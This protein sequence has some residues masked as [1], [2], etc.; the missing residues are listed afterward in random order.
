MKKQLLTLAVAGFLAMTLTPVQAEGMNLVR[1]GSF[2]QGPN[3]GGFLTFSKGSRDLLGWEIVKGSVDYIGTYFPN[4]HGKRSLDM[5][6]SAFGGIRQVVRTEPGK[7]YR[8]SFDMG[9][10]PDGPPYMKRLRVNA[11]A[12]T[13]EFTHGEGTTWHKK[14]MEF[15]ANSPMTPLEFISANT[16]AGAYGALLDNV[17]LEE[18]PSLA[19]PSRENLIVNGSF[20][21][22]IQPGEYKILKPGEKSVTGWI[23]TRDTV[24]YIGSY[25]PSSHGQRSLDLDGTPGF[26]GIRQEFRTEP[27]KK[28]RLTFDLAG[29]P[30]G[31][32]DYKRLGVKVNDHMA[33]FTHDAST[34]WTKQGLEFTAQG[35][36]TELEFFSMNREGD[37]YGPLLDNVVVEEAPEESL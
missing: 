4:A 3:P 29:N 27:G 23:I 31:A 10:N 8:L 6:G 36:T 33:I 16:E 19:G 30:E 13:R 15:T 37:Y 7:R 12:A 1:N 24:D 35:E 32:P 9:G 28:Y 17:R 26:G 34:N 5:D 25:F 11:G 20:E 21:E 18:I 22:G 2:E 14:T